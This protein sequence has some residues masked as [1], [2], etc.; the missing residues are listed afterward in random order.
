MYRNKRALFGLVAALVLVM[1][2][3]VSIQAAEM[4]HYW[5]SGGEKE[6]LDAFLDKARELYPNVEFTER[7]IQDQLRDETP[8]RCCLYGE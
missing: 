4:W 7:G 5:L 6:A 2:A 1:S 8:A 3:S